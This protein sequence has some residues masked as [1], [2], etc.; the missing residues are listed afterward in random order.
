MNVIIVGA[1]I[2]GLTLGNLL[3]QS[4]P[5]IHFQIFERDAAAHSRAQGY[6]VTLREPG[7]LIPLRQLSLYDEL[8]SV[9]SVV[10]NFPFL[11]QTGKPLL[12][13]RDNLASPR[14]L[15]VFRDKLR[16]ALLRDI[17]SGVH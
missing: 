11:T 13:L 1:G 15:R 2:G 14:T 17:Q 7:G 5:D 9:S 12:N 3:H 8:R 4:D 6:S 10:V 16:D